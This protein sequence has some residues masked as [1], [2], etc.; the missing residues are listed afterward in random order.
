MSPADPVDLTTKFTVQGA[1]I[2]ESNQLK[3]PS[4][5]LERLRQLDGYTWDESKQP[6]HSSY[7]IW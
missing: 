3:P 4:C 5:L 1:A 2:I 6:F 7:D